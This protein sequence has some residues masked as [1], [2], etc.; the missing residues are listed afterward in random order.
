MYATERYDAIERILHADGRLAVVDLAQR[1]DVTTETVRRDLAELERRGALT[2]V[3]GGAV[4]AARSSI[5]E[6]AIGDRVR[7]HSEA[8]RSIAAR[9]VATL[10]PGFRGSVFVDAGSTTAAVAAALPLHLRDTAGS[11]RVV[12]HSIALAPTLADADGID[13]SIIGGHIRG[14]TAAAVGAATVAAVSGLRP[15]VAFVGTNGLSAGFGLSTPDPE[16]AAV[17]TAIVEAARRVVIVCD[18]SKFERELLVG[19]APLSAID[20]LVTDAPPPE[21]LAGAL[22]DAEVEV[23]IA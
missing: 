14:V 9:A 17:K 12:T 16:E 10:G 19:F 22:A 13:L 6:T 3:H 11:A 20:A 7:E 1:F 15:D 4:A 5:R 21:P 18:A 2:R 8:K 23:L